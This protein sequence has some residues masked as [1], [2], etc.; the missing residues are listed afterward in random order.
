MEVMT[1]IHAAVSK[2]PEVFSEY[3]VPEKDA[4]SIGNDIDRR[5]KLTE[6]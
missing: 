1:E 6:T 5:L 4:V 3:G 2:W